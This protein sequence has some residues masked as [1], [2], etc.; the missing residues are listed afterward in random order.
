VAETDDRC[1]ADPPDEEEARRLGEEK[2]AR[3]A[4][5]QLFWAEA[6]GGMAYL[7]GTDVEENPYGRDQ[8]GLRVAWREGWFAERLKDQPKFDRWTLPEEGVSQPTV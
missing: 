7:A 4:E 8:L 2:E 6:Q 1:P 3:Q 5:A